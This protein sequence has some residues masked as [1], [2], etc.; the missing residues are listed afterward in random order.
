MVTFDRRSFLQQA[1]AATVALGMGATSLRVQA[2]ARA[3]P[4]ASGVSSRAVR[5]FL[6]TMSAGHALDTAPRITGEQDW[7][8]AFLSL[9][10]E[11]A[12]GSAFVHNSGATYMLSAIV[13]KVTGEKLTDYSGTASN[14]HRERGCRKRR[15]SRFNN[16]RPRRPVLKGR[17]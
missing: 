16:R 9:P 1:G 3:T 10:V 4:E 8:K 2:D 13:Q 15:R 7:V 6:L 11:N 12:P 17:A 5:A 14:C